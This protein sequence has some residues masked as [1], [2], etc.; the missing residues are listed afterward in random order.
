MFWWTEYV[1]KHKSSMDIP[2]CTRWHDDCCLTHQ[3]FVYGVAESWSRENSTWYR[4]AITQ[5]C[6]GCIWENFSNYIPVSAPHNLC[7]LTPPDDRLK[8]A[9][10]YMCQKANPHSVFDIHKMLCSQRKMIKQFD[11]N[12]WKAY[13]NFLNHYDLNWH[14]RIMKNNLESGE[15]FFDCDKLKKLTY[16]YQRAQLPIEDPNWVKCQETGEYRLRSSVDENH[17]S[18]TLDKPYGLDSLSYYEKVE[19]IFWD[20]ESTPPQCLV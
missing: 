2:Y 6:E 8:I 9:F 1:A 7:I 19:S 14:T 3:I 5:N 12:F 18:I 20:L 16:T 4:D 15:M 13:P 11:G 17:V 10:D